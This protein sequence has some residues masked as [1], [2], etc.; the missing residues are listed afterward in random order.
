[1]KTILIAALLAAGGLTPLSA[2]PVSI[3][4][5]GIDVQSGAPEPASVVL[6]SL[7]ALG[8]RKMKK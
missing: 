5:G 4:G 3:L 7:V 2:G 6:C 1:M 8:V